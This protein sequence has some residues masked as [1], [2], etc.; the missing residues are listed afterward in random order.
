MLLLLA[1]PLHAQPAATDRVRVVEAQLPSAPAAVAPLTKVL[2]LDGKESYLLLPDNI[3]TG[4]TEITV[5]TW[6]NCSF[7]GN[8]V[9][10]FRAD[11]DD[12]GLGLNEYGFYINPKNNLASLGRVNVSDRIPTWRH[13]A[14]VATPATMKF[15][16]DGVLLQSK[17]VKT[18]FSSVAGSPNRVGAGW[19]KSFMNGRIAEFRIWKVARSEAQIRSA[20]FQGL[21]G[22][23]S[24]LLGLW[25]FEKIENGVVRDSGP[26]GFDGKMAGNARVVEERT[27]SN[28]TGAPITAALDLDGNE[29]YLE[30]PAKLY[31]NHVVTVEGWAKW[32]V[33]DSHQRFFA[34]FDS[35]IQMDL[36]SAAASPNLLLE[37]FRGSELQDSHQ[38]RVRDVL[39][40]DRWAHFAVVAGSNFAKLYVDGALVSENET[41]LGFRPDPLPVFRNTLGRD[42]MKGAR[43]LGTN[44]DLNGQ[45]AEVR[46]WAGERTT[47][48]IKDN[49]FTA[50]SGG[51]PGLL[52]L[53]NFSDPKQPGR[54]ASAHGRD[55]IP[56]GN[57]KVVPAQLPGLSSGLSQP[58]VVYGKVTGEDGQPLEARIQVEQDGQQVVELE[59]RREDGSFYFVIYATDKPVAMGL[60]GRAKDSWEWDGE[61]GAWELGLK[62]QPGE[63][64]EAN[65]VLKPI[66]HVNG[67]V[68]S[69]DT[70]QPLSGILVQAM[71]VSQVEGQ[72]A[73]PEFFKITDAKGAFDFAHLKPGSYW[74]RCHGA[75]GFIDRTNTV[76]VGKPGSVLEREDGVTIKLPTGTASVKGADWASA[77]TVA[78]I[79]FTILPP[80][81][82]SWKN[83]DY[84]H[85]L[86][87]DA[88]YQMTFGGDGALWLATAGGVSQF[89]GREFRNWTKDEGLL[90]NNVLA[91]CA[92][93]GGA[94]WVSSYGVGLSRFDPSTRSWRYFT[95][96]N[97]LLANDS[98]CLLRDGEA[99]WVGH[100]NGVSRFDSALDRAGRNAWT[101]FPVANGFPIHSVLGMFRDKAGAL[102]IAG[103]GNLGPL[104]RMAGTNVVTF[105]RPEGI[106]AQ[107]MRAF[108]QDADGTLWVG[109]QSGDGRGGVFRYDPAAAKSGGKPFVRFGEK[110]GLW[111]DVMAIHRDASGVLWFGSENYQRLCRYD[112]KSFLYFD[113][114]DF[115]KFSVNSIL[116]SPAGDG[117]L[118][119][120]TQGGGLWRFDPDSFLAVG[121][122]DGY[123]RP[124]DWRTS[125]RDFGDGRL[126]IANRNLG[127]A[128]YDTNGLTRFRD[129]GL[130]LDSVSQVV[131]T[132]EG[133][134]WAVGAWN[135]GLARLDPSS[136]DPGSWILRAF[137]RSE[138]GAQVGWWYAGGESTLLPGPDH[139]FWLRGF[140]GIV[141]YNGAGG[142]RRLTS[143]DGIPTGFPRQLVRGADG[144]AWINMVRWDNNEGSPTNMNSLVRVNGT[145]MTRF[146]Q[147]DG[148]A[149]GFHRLAASPDGG[150]WI[151]YNWDA[152]NSYGIGYFNGKTIENFT[153]R[154]GL[155]YNQVSSVFCEPSG[156]AWFILGNNGVCRFDP[157]SRKF[158]AFSTAK[159]R[160]A[161]NDVGAIYRDHAGVLWFGT[162]R[163]FT[164]Y[165]GIAWSS[166]DARDGVPANAIYTFEKGTN[167]SMWLATDSGLANFRPRRL[168]LKPPRL[169]VQTDTNYTDLA[170]IPPITSGRLITFRYSAIDFRTR[171]EN[172]QYRIAVVPGEPAAPLAADWREPSRGT[173]FGWTTN[174]T[175]KQTF[176]VQY[177]DRDL[178]YS[179]P[180]RVVI[181]I[182]PP[183]YANAWIMAPSGS[184]ALGLFGWA[185]MAR[186]MVIRR[187]REAEQLR[188]Q[189][190]QQERRARAE[191]EAKNAQL[192]A[193]RISA[194]AAREQAEAANAAKSEFLANMSHEIRTPMNAILG[195]SELLRAQMAASKDRNYLDAITSSGRTLLTLIND[196]L[197]LSKIEAG[198]LELQ[199]EPV[200]VPRLV[201]EIQKLFSI[202]AG[203][204]GLK[205]LIEIDSKLPRGL[206]LD[207]VRLRQVLFNVVGN[208]LKFTEQGH[209]KI[210]AWAEYGAPAGA[211]DAVVA[212]PHPGP[213]LQG[214]QG[215]GETSTALDDPN[216]PRERDTQATVLPL[217]GERAG[218]REDQPS[219]MT[220]AGAPTEPDETRVNLILEVSDTGIGI[221]EA[222]QEH[223][224]GAFSQV[225][226]QSTRKFGGTGLGL[227]I[228][229]RLTEMMHG[230]IQVRS[231]PGQGSTFR[232]VFPNVTITE[233][234]ESD[235]IPASGDGDFDQFAPATILVADDVVLNRQLLTGYFEGTAH[236]LITATN[237]VEALEQAEKHRPD[238]ILM[239]MR[240]P[241]LDGHETTKR[242]KANAALK[243]IP[244]IAVTASSFREEEARARKICDGFI[245]KPFNR[246][247]LIA[248]LKRF[249]KLAAPK[250]QPASA[251][252]PAAGAGASAPAPSEVVAR[253]P[254][255]VEMLR[256]Q[257]QTV[258][259]R[260]CKTLATG[261]IEG[262]A[263]G[264]RRCAEE[265]Q[266]PSLCSYAEALEQQVQEFDFSR[267]P[268]TLQR[269]PDVIASLP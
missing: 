205:L 73:Q 41:P 149:P 125:L 137:D 42:P 194:E 154:D 116:S 153:T 170:D 256:Q 250:S 61:V 184:V 109:G 108:W 32:R 133:A 69:L 138:I 223:I 152:T 70:N 31:T 97:G 66:L 37:H 4:L 196:I 86:V 74:F 148:L 188:E 107:W 239:D 201:E 17:D 227:T 93:S 161:Q 43:N 67:T 255:L 34:F 63:R 258:W 207:E 44:K 236:Q 155:P 199:Y 226:G 252:L 128:C 192:E 224:F 162:G 261:E 198:K 57:A 144:S 229:K 245:R 51:E 140:D 264:L 40:A 168:E 269:F 72:P 267:L 25:N 238:I 146:T 235:A 191:M 185:F 220:P 211:S 90:G 9:W 71:K 38:I 187:K 259:P 2:E 242:L 262:F 134:I 92:D 127:L 151:Q 132:G 33:F 251:V 89:D 55:G 7:D 143:D 209:V 29:S 130:N 136:S 19:P 22:K 106:I 163:G 119:V 182:A 12:M 166:L 219:A 203:E 122:G 120:A 56:R 189:M 228:T 206:M 95:V 114:D 111:F 112:G 18:S 186:S 247:E 123:D 5:E 54:D 217:L 27:P 26:N 15:Y 200:C 156:R 117:F 79:H 157:K 257:E 82:G 10:C 13:L 266:W 222:Q 6:V 3:L 225:A 80:K 221:P 21:T 181:E 102:W 202:K 100:G 60:R 64:K 253:R 126:W 233:L 265:G 30:L 183:W 135:R 150:L 158:D 218:V 84:T 165:D 141:Q 124:S 68:H 75:G 139:S 96:T 46:L 195:F 174:K 98:R 91:L 14:A 243:H 213:L 28:S 246:S 24:G 260:L 52:A 230:V 208:A 58:A 215:E 118:W 177:I 113:K 244:V 35:S 85:G 78:T 99:I 110:D 101:Q 11:R 83:Y 160:L 147:M 212:R 171:P 237:G 167:G 210:R 103:E 121:A 39:V 76:V 180:A 49:R 81:K 62:V 145:N 214:P 193:S 241:E 45:L 179:Q 115:K 159:G 47:R 20:M 234:A 53:W 249:L 131:K 172:Q 268:Q 142:F 240:M 232:F 263:R 204:K 190:F 105:G 164:R 175:G 65:L 87:H 178:N 129:K 77:Q 16:L 104:A 197:D 231:E 1:G 48:Q 94:M 88:I 173:E 50:L 254:A 176:F 248:E 23:E 216:A 36:L 169:S 8:R 59:S